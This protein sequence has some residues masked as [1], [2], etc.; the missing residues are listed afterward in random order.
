[1]HKQLQINWRKTAGIWSIR[2]NAKQDLDSF[3]NA[4]F[5]QHIDFGEMI[6]L[7][8]LR[9]IRLWPVSG[10]LLSEQWRLPDSA[11]GFET[12]IT[13]ISHGFCGISLSGSAALPFLND[14]CSADLEQ[15]RLNINRCL[16]TSLG[17]YSVLIWWDDASEIHLLIERSYAQSFKQFLHAIAIRWLG[18]GDNKPENRTTPRAFL[19]TLCQPIKTYPKKSL[20]RRWATASIKAWNGRW[21]SVNIFQ[22]A[23]C[24]YVRWRRK[25]VPAPCRYAKPWPA[26]H[27]KGCCCLR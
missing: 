14:Y 22:V 2:T 24:R 1:M 21:L 17:Q 20:R 25:W 27:L 16:R 12:M 3:A 9:L 15:A 26:W 4:I 8:N 7:D 13:D 18:S 19:W 5:H 10:Y 6:T 23:T 11:S